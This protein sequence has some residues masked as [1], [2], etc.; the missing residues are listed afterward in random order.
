MMVEER[1][2]GRMENRGRKTGRTD[3]KRSP[4][5]QPNQK[6]NS[7]LATWLLEDCVLRFELLDTF[8]C[9][10]GASI[11]C[12]AESQMQDLKTN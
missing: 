6:R 7:V 11:V 5:K 4:R 9:G 3:V 10:V 2:A 8:S 12:A 1:N